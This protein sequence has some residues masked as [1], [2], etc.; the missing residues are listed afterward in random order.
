MQVVITGAAGMLGTRLARRLL[1][2][3]ELTG[4]DG[5]RQAIEKLVLFDVVAAG[6]FD[7]PRVAVVTGDIAD[8]ATVD[9]LIENGT[10]SV[11]HLAGVVSAAAE[12]DFPLGLSVNLHGA[13]NLLEACRRLPV[14]PRLVFTSSIATY[15][16]DL[17]DCITDRTPQ[18]P[19]TS[20]GSQ[21]AAVELL[22]TD[23]SRK[24]YVDGRSLRLPT[25]MV[26]PGR[27][28]K[29]AST[30]ASSIIREP[31]TGIDAVCPVSP[32]SRMACMS[33]RRC[34][35]AFL[36][37]HEAPTHAFGA[38]RSLLLSGITVRADEMVAAMQRQGG[39]DI[40]QVI[41][42]PDPA[43]QAIVDGWPGECRGDRAEALGI[44]TDPDIDAIVRAFIEDDLEDQRRLVFDSRTE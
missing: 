35:E 39:N 13:L 17:P 25:I 29:A 21:K 31:L 30:W 33:P 11:F 19:Q 28:N 42:Q 43:I 2:E 23:Y 4:P 15:G 32:A 34:I 12:A 14:A 41:W 1:A 10:G 7:D 36:I 44:H 8:A 22:V 6:P 9:R 18:T 16:G 26:R 24:G 20:Y 5:R 27:P 40:G 3:G 38:S 37:A